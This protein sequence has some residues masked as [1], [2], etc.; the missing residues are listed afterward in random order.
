M[1]F[2]EF[3]RRAARTA[4]T[5]IDPAVRRE[6]CALGLYGEAGELCDVIKKERG[7]GHPKNP[8]AVLKEAGD[9]LWYIAEAASVDHR[10]LEALAGKPDGSGFPATAAS[11]PAKLARLYARTMADMANSM[12]YGGISATSVH[13]ALQTLSLLLSHY[14]HTLDDAMAFVIAKLEKRYAEGFTPEASMA[15]VDVKPGA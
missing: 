6:V 10:D 8:V 5:T 9:G 3:Q 13:F 7:H 15:R 11:N 4:N 1:R 2:S 12:D 14:G